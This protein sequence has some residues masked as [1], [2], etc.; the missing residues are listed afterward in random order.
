[1]YQ[2]IKELA[3]TTDRN[4][5]DLCA[6]SPYRDPFF[7][8]SS[9]DV[10]TV[11]ITMLALPGDYVQRLHNACHVAIPLRKATDNSTSPAIFA[12]GEGSPF[13]LL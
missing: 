8:G 13:P 11:Q 6:L 9:L 10:L 12:F 4:I 2:D 3:K 5:K 1:M 7:T